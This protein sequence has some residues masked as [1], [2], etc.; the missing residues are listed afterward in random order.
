M[1]IYSKQILYCNVCGQKMCKEIP[2][3]IGKHCKVCSI[4]CCEEFN[5]RNTLSIM[6][7]EYRPMEKNKN[8]A[9]K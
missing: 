7:S 5:W 9:E 6:G 2:F 4:E 3:L 8:E 1:A